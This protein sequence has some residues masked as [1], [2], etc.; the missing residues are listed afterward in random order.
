MKISKMLSEFP[1]TLQVLI[2]FSPHFS[3]LNNKLLRKTLASRVNVEQAAGIA[4]VNLT[5]LLTKLNDVINNKTI[6][7]TEQLENFKEEMNENTKPER[8]DKISPDK[9]IKLD[10]RP[11]IDSGKDPF[12]EIMQAIKSL[13]DDDVLHLINSFEPMP[14][15]SV[16]SNKGYEHW[17]EKVGDVFN[18]Y[19]FKDNSKSIKTE[20]GKEDAKTVNTDLKKVI[21]IDV[22]ELAPPEPMIKVLESL[23]EVDEETVLV[24]H[25]HREPAMLYPKLEE[26]GYTAM[27]NKIEENY[28][29]VIITKKRNA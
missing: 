26:R 18:V 11:T 10:V 15:Y 29:K 21:E 13:K 24:V 22:R 2:N 27:T 1:E 6:F 9:F 8:L 16:L 28:Y 3:K 23:S 12:L 14:L 20:Q 25:H 5:I 17:T 7:Q 19:F 4:G